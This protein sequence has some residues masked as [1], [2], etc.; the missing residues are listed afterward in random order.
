MKKRKLHIKL[1]LNELHINEYL[2]YI[3]YYNKMI[4]NAKIR[5]STSSPGPAKPIKRFKANMTTLDAYSRTRALNQT[6]MTNV[7]KLYESRDIKNIKTAKAA[8]EL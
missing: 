1:K 2:L 8:M 4:N 5:K 7:R 3:Y 6:H